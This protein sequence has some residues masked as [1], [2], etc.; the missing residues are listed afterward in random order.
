[1]QQNYITAPTPPPQINKLCLG[2][3]KNIDKIFGASQKLKKDEPLKK[4]YNSNIKTCTW[5]IL[6]YMCFVI[7]SVFWNIIL[8]NMGRSVNVNHV[9]YLFQTSVSE[10]R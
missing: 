10:R 8:Y 4:I 3:S 1:M 7:W 2:W 9:V 6:G 5:K